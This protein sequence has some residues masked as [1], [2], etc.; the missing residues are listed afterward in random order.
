MEFTLSTRAFLCN[1]YGKNHTVASAKK[2]DFFLKREKKRRCFFAASSKMVCTEVPR[3]IKKYITAT[4]M[5]IVNKCFYK[6][7]SYLQGH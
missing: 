1:D 3:F 4:Y 6:T 5:Q 7:E 2:G